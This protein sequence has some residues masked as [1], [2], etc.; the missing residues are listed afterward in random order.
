MDNKELLTLALIAAMFA[1][2]FAL[3]PQ[4]PLR[5]PMHWNAEGIIDGWGPQWTLFLVPV[6]AAVMY[7]VFLY[8]P[9]LDPM[10]KNVDEFYKKHG[11]GFKFA[12][13]LFM[14]ALEAAIIAAALGISVPMSLAMPLALSALFA[15]LGFIMRKI[16]RNY[17]IG[18]R[19]P[20][21]LA[22][23]ENWKKT[24]E[25][26][27]KAFIAAGVASFIGAFLPWSFWILMASIMLAVF[28]TFAY[29]YLEFRKK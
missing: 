3:M 11:F 5:V 13:M 14:A 22:S 21:A 18:F 2:P 28:A 27:G 16:K 1:V 9:K 23:D 15:Y 4:M 6:M 12:F 20:W 10:R 29:S 26:G 19:T 8:L 25:F 24:H 7:L 17:F